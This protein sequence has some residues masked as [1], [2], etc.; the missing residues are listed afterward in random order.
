MDKG[1]L[2]DLVEV[3]SEDSMLVILEIFF[4]HFLV[5]EWVDEDRDPVLNLMLVKI[6]RCDSVFHLKMLSSV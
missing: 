5:V 3:F 1:D 6:S 2:V 4:H